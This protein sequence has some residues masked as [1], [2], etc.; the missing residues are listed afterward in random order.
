MFQKSKCDFI[1]YSTAVESFVSSALPKFHFRY[2]S[3]ML[4]PAFIR[5]EFDI[6]GLNGTVLIID[7]YHTTS[8][9]R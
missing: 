8:I 3:V 2:Q 4:G 5:E 7:L 9:Y 6:C 1:D